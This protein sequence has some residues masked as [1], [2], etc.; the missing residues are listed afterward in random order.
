MSDALTTFYLTRHGQTDWNVKNINLGG[1]SDIPLNKTGEKQAGILAKKIR[2]I[3]FDAIISSDL[4]RARRTAEII[5]LEHKLI[6]ETY[7]ALRERDFGSYDGEDRTRYL[8]DLRALEKLTDEEI[9]K[10][11]LDSTI[12]S[13]DEAA[14]RLITFLREYAIGYPG[15][16]ILVVCHGSIIRALLIKLG[17]ETMRN[18][19]SGCIENT[20]YVVVESDGVDFF[21][22]ETYGVNKQL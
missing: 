19:P 1:K 21:I 14:S 3:H 13:Q 18:L 11:K 12:E 10:H 9:F 15:K 7:E 16:S 20:A 6:V 4:I 17:F 8:T 22:T 5:A 2:H